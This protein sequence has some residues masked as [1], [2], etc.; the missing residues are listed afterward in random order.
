MY[1]LCHSPWSDKYENIH[2]SRYTEQVKAIIALKSQQIKSEAIS[3]SKVIYIII[4][5]NFIS[6]AS[7]HIRKS[8]CD[9]NHY[10]QDTELILI[11][12]IQAIIMYIQVSACVA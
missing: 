2:Q 1:I 4:T 7:L 10:V 6:I 5:S 8:T 3:Y 9:I 12:Y 11:L